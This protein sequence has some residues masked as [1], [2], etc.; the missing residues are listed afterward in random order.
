MIGCASVARRTQGT[1]QKKAAG[2][3]KRR[4][5]P[6][7]PPRHETPD[8]DT[9]YPNARVIKRY[10]NRRLYDGTLSRCVTMDEI[11]EFV[12]KG[13]D[14]RVVDGDS[15]EDLTKRVL[16]Q[17]ILE[18]SN[19]RVLELL[20]VEFLRR[21]ITVRTD[22]ASEWVAQYL[23]MGAELM[24]KQMDVSGPASRLVQDS[25]MSMFPWMKSWVQEREA[26]PPAGGSD[27]APREDALRDQ[28]E[29]LQRRLTDL[30]AQMRPPR[31]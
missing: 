26:P 23:T 17:I 27:E 9:R 28:V 10:G 1:S 13:E 14:V 24:Q 8:V 3:A 16:T 15:G 31:R 19:A 6:G 5:G 12:R 20:P 30:T 25:M 29:E 2:T 21:L 22:A 7:R 11:A 4:R 18:S